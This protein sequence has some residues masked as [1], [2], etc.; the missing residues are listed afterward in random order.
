MLKEI[1]HLWNA[2]LA[3]VENVSGIS[4]A[5]SLEPLP[6]AIYAHKPPK[7]NPLGFSASSGSMVVTLL[8]ATWTDKSDDATIEKTARDLFSAIEDQARRLGVYEPFIYLNYA[9]PW[10]DPIASYGEDNVERLKLVS[11]KVDPRGIF[12]FGVPGGFKILP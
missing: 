4:W 2:S 9:A 7:T 11:K 5:I 8:S 1:Y 12:Q 3:A 10:Q 6:P